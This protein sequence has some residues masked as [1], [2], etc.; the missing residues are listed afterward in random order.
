MRVAVMQP[1]F[2]PYVGYWQ[3]INS[4]DMF[5]I[6]DDVNYI[7][8]GWINRNRILINGE[9]HMITLSLQQSSQ[10]KQINN[11]LVGSNKGKILKTI[12]N[13]YKKA[14]YFTE[15]YLLVEELMNDNEQRLSKFLGNTIQSL[16]K[17]LELSTKIVYSSDLAFDRQKKG[18]D[19]IIEIAEY[20]QASTYVNL[21]GG[22][23]L[24]E[25]MAFQQRE[26]KLEFLE[27]NNFNYKQFSNYFVPWLSIIDVMMFNN[28]S[29]IKFYL[30]RGYSLME[31]SICKK[32]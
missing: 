21:I 19:K 3:L 6:Y 28:I 13:V 7:N 9:A 27:S 15:V 8:R 30:E 26:I 31:P 29:E 16:T 5:V 17:Y 12:S 2:F 20:L 23:A 14:P 24:Y 10:N 22:K 25:N 32:L 11:I 18:Q 1:Y 4:A